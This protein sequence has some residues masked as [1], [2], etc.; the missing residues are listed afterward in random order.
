MAGT[1]PAAMNS[2]PRSQ[3]VRPSVMR[4][5]RT[6]NMSTPA[7]RN[8]LLEAGMA[9]KSP[10]WVP[11]TTTKLAT[12]SPSVTVWATSVWMSGAAVYQVP[13]WERTVSAPPPPDPRP[14][15]PT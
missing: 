15:W 6:R 11:S 1:A 12:H 2:D 5:S 7:I 10:D 14:Q 13:R 3:I 8:G 4:P 9:E